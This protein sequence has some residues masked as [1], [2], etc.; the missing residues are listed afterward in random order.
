MLGSVPAGLLSD[1]FVSLMCCL[2]SSSMRDVFSGDKKHYN[3]W[4]VCGRNF[5]HSAGNKSID[6]ITVSENSIIVP[7]GPLYFLE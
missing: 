2:V 1:K 3:N 7:L 4:D 6:P 5:T